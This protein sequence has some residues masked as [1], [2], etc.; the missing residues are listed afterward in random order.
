MGVVPHS[1]DKYTL[2]FTYAASMVIQSCKM[3][4]YTLVALA[5][6]RDVEFMHLQYEETLKPR[7]HVHMEN[8]IT[9][10]KARKDI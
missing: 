8:F 9:C 10:H 5:L 6:G 4:L 7:R 3:I 2:M 1:M